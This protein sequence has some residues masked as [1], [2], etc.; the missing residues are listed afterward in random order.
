[1]A[2]A[3]MLE[4]LPQG[5]GVVSD[6]TLSIRWAAIAEPLVL[7]ERFLADR[8]VEPDDPVLFECDNSVPGVLTMLALLARRGSF[9]FVPFPRPS[10]LTVGAPSF[11]RWR[12]RVPRGPL[13]EGMLAR[14]DSFIELDELDTHQPLP[15]D[16][17]LRRGRLVFRTSGSLGVPK[18]VVHGHDR[19]I[20]NSRNAI[21]RLRLDS[22]D[23]V[24][25][26]VP[27]AHMYGF[28]AALIPALLAGAS[29]DLLAGANV[30]RYIERERKVEPT[31]A[32][33]TPNLCAT[34]VRSRAPRAHYRHVVVAGD[35]LSPELFE[36]LETIY[37]RVVNLYGSSEMGVVCA[38]DPLSRTGRRAATV[39]CPLPGV[40]LMVERSADT[41][42]GV[43]ELLCRHPF[44]FEGYVGDDLELRS[45]GDGA[46][47]TRDLA[48]VEADGLVELLGR[49][50]HAVKRDGRLVPLIEIERALERLPG[51]ARAAAIISGQSM[52]GRGIVAFCMPKADAALM[53]PAPLRRACRQHL[54]AFAV[55]DEIRIL[56]RLP[57]LPSG[58]LDRSTLQRISTEPSRPAS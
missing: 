48:R 3:E 49:C 9:V 36:K 43:G 2:V 35:K 46:Y 8:G 26:P 22:A 18:L 40:E 19:V 7:L 12:L 28:G 42:D 27:V 30:I 53:E 25:I 13:A 14:P 11:C 1:M 58:K 16:H 45:G 15:K 57:L 37:G 10:A 33:L 31:V 55:P 23:R 51:V 21:E 4:R 41:Q 52:R 34:L 20:E 39:G 24:L 38:A 47:R 50:D 17:A 29:V 56:P 44:G 5:D 32:F 54:P 6:A